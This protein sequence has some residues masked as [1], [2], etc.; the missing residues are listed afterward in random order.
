MDFQSLIEPLAALL[1]ASHLQ[2]FKIPA[3]EERLIANLFVDDTTTFLSEF[4]NFED[5][6]KILKNWCNAS[7][8]KFNI[9]KTEI[10]P[11]G[12]PEFRAKVFNTQRMTEA[13]EEI[14]SHIH[15]VK[16]G[17]PVRILG[18]WVGNKI[19]NENIWSTQLNKIDQALKRWEKSNPTIEGR[20][21]ITQMTV[22]GMTQYLTQ[23]QGM[24]AAVEK[25]LERRAKI[26]I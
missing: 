19:D 23:V 3:N 8:A 10:I 22:G 15:I 6:Q 14:P 5:L 18:A 16:D 2:G 20:K 24:P 17:E 1:R 21:L 11:I 26:F 9:Q 12:T 25:K 7:T 13:S 4:D